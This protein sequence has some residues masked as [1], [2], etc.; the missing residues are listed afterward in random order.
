[1]SCVTITHDALE[2]TTQGP[3]PPS[4]AHPPTEILLVPATASPDMFKLLQLGLHCTGSLP[5][6]GMFKLFHYEAHTVGR[7]VVDI[8]LECFLVFH[9]SAHIWMLDGRFLQFV[10]LFHKG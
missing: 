5:S 9:I 1:M 2:L 4:A 10:C 6:Q 3:P 7:R 8:L